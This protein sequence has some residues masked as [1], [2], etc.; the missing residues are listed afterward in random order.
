LLLF[1]F[2][3]KSKRKEHVRKRWKKEKGDKRNQ[4]LKE[5]FKEEE[6]EEYF[7]HKK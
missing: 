1:L 5:D 2:E 6:E 7:H 3:Y 4:S